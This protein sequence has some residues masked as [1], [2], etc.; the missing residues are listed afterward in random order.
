[1]FP[2]VL[3]IV[4]SLYL[5]Q[6]LIISIFFKKKKKVISFYFNWIQESISS[7][8]GFLVYILDE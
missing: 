2:V 8:I 3:K 7:I 4:D 5:N 1:M 6:I